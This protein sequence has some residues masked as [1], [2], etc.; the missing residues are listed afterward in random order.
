MSMTYEYIFV[1]DKN[2][3]VHFPFSRECYVINFSPL[4]KF[5]LFFTIFF[6]C[7]ALHYMVQENCNFIHFYFYFY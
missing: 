6:F 3:Y 7:N 2:N 1:S 5:H 4:L